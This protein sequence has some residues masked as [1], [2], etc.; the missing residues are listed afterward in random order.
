MGYKKVMGL[1]INQTD[2]KIWIVNNSKK[3][4]V[5]TNSKH[6]TII[7]GRTY[8]TSKFGRWLKI[9]IKEE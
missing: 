5:I 3:D 7:T 1:V 6:S 9:G 8:I 2:T 4:L